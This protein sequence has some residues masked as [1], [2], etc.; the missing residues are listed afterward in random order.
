MH[1]AQDIVKALARI[2]NDFANLEM[3]KAPLKH[4][5]TRDGLEMIVAIGGDE[6]PGDGPIREEAII[7]DV[8]ALGLV[9]E[10]GFAPSQSSRGSH[11]RRAW[12]GG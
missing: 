2:A 12:G 4:P 11:G 5:K 1:K 3:G 7:N 9:A 10:V 6:G 8:E